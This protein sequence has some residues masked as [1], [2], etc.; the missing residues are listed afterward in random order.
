MA[1]VA[2]LD[3]STDAP[4][5]AIQQSYHKHPV[6]TTCSSWLRVSSISALW[7]IGYI[8]ASVMGSAEVT[9]ATLAWTSSAALDLQLWTACLQ[10]TWTFLGPKTIQHFPEFFPVSCIFLFFY[11][12][13]AVFSAWL[14]MN[15]LSFWTGMFRLA[16]TFPGSGQTISLLHVTHECQFRHTQLA[17]FWSV[18][19]LHYE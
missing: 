12:Y 4:S 3:Y 18:S 5:I 6:N 16:G 2:H 17:F 15:F 7:L 9:I 19:F 11:V 13:S 14:G 8:F 1:V 10:Y